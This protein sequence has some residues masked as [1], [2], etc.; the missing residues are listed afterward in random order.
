MLPMLRQFLGDFL[1]SSEL[2]QFCF[3]NKASPLQKLD[4]SFTNRD[5]VATLVRKAV[6]TKF[7]AGQHSEGMFE[8][9]I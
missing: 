1:Y 4:D 3:E 7:S 6:V 8:E 9:R 2:A 5:T